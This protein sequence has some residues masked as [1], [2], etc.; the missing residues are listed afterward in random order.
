MLK[1]ENVSKSFGGLEILK[2]VSLEVKQGNIAALIGPNGAGKT[3]VFNCVTGLVKPNQ[4]SI[5]L[6]GQ[7]LLE[8]PCHEIST[9]GLS[10]TF[11]NIRI[12][13]EMTLLENVLVGKHA[14]L[15]YSSL[16]SLLGL[17]HFKNA[18]KKA[19]EEA[20]ELLKWFGLEKK[21]TDLASN[22]SYG[23]QRRLEFARALATEP[24]ILLLDEPV[25]GMN[26]AEKIAL[27]EELRQIR[28]RGVTIFLI[29][30]DM[31]F[32]MGLCDQVSVLNFGEIIARG[33]PSEIQANP[34]VIEAYLGVAEEELE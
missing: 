12:F 16:S 15:K 18:E 1:I 32:V 30:H 3:T 23:E 7:S 14:H 21:A 5:T 19:I 8:R 17:P 25:A 9:L 2:N 11:Q 20:Y 34:L 4:G 29:E 27:M 33:T 22:L 26:Q 28:E 24:K 13:K 31:G 6:L 10:R